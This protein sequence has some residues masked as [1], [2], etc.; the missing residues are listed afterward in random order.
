MGAL[1]APNFTVYISNKRSF[2]KSHQANQ[3]N[4]PKLWENS[5]TF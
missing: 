5:F 3:L 1:A 4:G 2:W